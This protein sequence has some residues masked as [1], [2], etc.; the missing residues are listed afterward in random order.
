MAFLLKRWAPR[1]KIRALITHIAGDDWKLEAARSLSY[2]EL[3][4][5]ILDRRRL[6]WALRKVAEARTK[7]ELLNSLRSIAK[8][9][10]YL[11]TPEV[12]VHRLIVW[13]KTLIGSSA[14]DK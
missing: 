4:T 10:G 8:E 13:F 9:L 5:L 2:E 6:D 12:Q 1:R 3:R 7:E 14:E 11:R